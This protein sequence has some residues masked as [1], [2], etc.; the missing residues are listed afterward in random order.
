MADDARARLLDGWA[1]RT[2]LQ[3]I[4]HAQRE[5]A[6]VAA[7]STDDE[8]VTGCVGAFVVL[9]GTIAGLRERLRKATPL[10]G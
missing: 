1:L 4:Q 7:L 6:D 10:Q 8:V 3:R 5:L 2:A 9:E